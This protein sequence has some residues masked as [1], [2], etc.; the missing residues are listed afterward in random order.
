MRNCVKLD[1]RFL[2]QDSCGGVRSSS[3]SSF[4]GASQATIDST[5]DLTGIGERAIGF[6]VSGN[7][8]GAFADA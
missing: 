5:H 8:M 4:C 7:G 2:A 1:S 3:E 6:L